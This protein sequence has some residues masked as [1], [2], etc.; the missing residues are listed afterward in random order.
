MIQSERILSANRDATLH[1]LRSVYDERLGEGVKHPF[2]TSKYANNR[3][4][5]L[6][7]VFKIY[8]DNVKTKLLV[9]NCM[10]VLSRPN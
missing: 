7:I 2:K 10:V 5:G 8:F 3:I 9:V 6:D 1:Q 4:L